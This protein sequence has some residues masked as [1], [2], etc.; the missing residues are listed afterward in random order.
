MSEEYWHQ[1]DDREKKD[2]IQWFYN[3]GPTLAFNVLANGFIVPVVI[4]FIFLSVDYA[5]ESLVMSLA[6]GLAAFCF[7]IYYAV[8]LLPIVLGIPWSVG[9]SRAEDRTE[10]HM[11]YITGK[12]E[13]VDWSCVEDWDVD[14]MIGFP[15]VYIRTID[16]ESEVFPIA[17]RRFESALFELGEVGR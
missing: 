6:Y 15:N 10:V 8:F 1:I 16:G 17:N 5:G 12:W 13:F 4:L 3:V 11:R 9:I 14:K 7:A 2:S